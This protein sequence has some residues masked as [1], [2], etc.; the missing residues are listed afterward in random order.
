MTE[1]K[2]DEVK[3]W[4]VKIEKAEKD[5]EP[6]YDLIKE[7]REYYR[8][9][10]NKNK[11]NIFWSSIET[12]K[13]FLYFKQPRPYVERKEKTANTIASIACQIMEKALAWSLEQFDFD[14]AIKYARNDFLLVGAGILEEKYQAEFE[15]VLVED[16]PTEVKSSE[17]VITSY[18]NPEDFLIDREKVGVWED[19]T[20]VAR[21]IWMKKAEVIAVFGEE[22]KRL[23]VAPGE[24]EYETKDTLVYKVWDK[25]NKRI[26]YLSKECKTEYLKVSEDVLNVKG[27]FPF[28]K[29]I[30][31]TQTNDSLIP[32]PD[33]SQIKS[34]LSE[35]D[36]ITSRMKLTMQALKVSGAYD[37]SFPELVSILNKDTSLVALRDFQKLKEAGGIKGIIDFIPIGQYLDTLAGL[38]QRRDEVKARL[39]EI[40]GISDIMRGNSNPNETATAVKQKTNFGSL[41]N[42]DRQNDMQRFIT[43]LLKIKAEIICEQFSVETLAQFAGANMDPNLLN[44]AINLLKQ[45]K[46]RGMTLGIETDIA[47][48]QDAVAQKSL[49]VMKTI[50][51]MMNTAGQVVMS[52]P[53]LLPLYRQMINSVVVTLPNARQFEA[54]IE[55]VFNQ[56]QQSLSQPKPQMPNPQIMAVQNQA[57]KN[58][59]DFMIKQEQNRLKAQEVALKNQIEQNK[60]MLTE[61]EMDLQAMLKQ[62]E[63]DAKKETNTNITTG[64]VRGF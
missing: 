53:L 15:T 46:L 30:F 45:D 56:I 40:T 25:E 4:F 27:F 17:K 39:Y 14:S 24:K 5:Y 48:N 49:E 2:V 1:N 60:V 42:Q 28:P 55:Q 35:M 29:P 13:P 62:E 63:N 47:F 38:A 11:D 31:A 37:S 10:K 51:E 18:V 6:Y 44:Q 16:E 9:E 32:V 59:Q 22:V 7:I 41:R 20:W 57:Q 3:K 34:L 26:C 33:Y 52:Q 36:G 64:Y 43:D 54:T 21:K 58:Q 12:L 23:I 61:K 8:N 19:V 50:N